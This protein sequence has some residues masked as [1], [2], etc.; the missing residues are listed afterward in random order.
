MYQKSA[1]QA[2]LLLVFLVAFGCTK[3]T[4]SADTAGGG[5][6][7]ALAS[8]SDLENAS[9]S[10]EVA[11]SRAAIGKA[12]E[13][14][15]LLQQRLSAR[16][17]EAMSG[18]GPAAAIE[19]CSEEAQTIATEVGNDLGVKIGRTSFKLR[20]SS[21]QPPSWA[22]SFVAEKTDKPQHLVLDN[23]DTATLLPI[24]LQPQCTACHGDAEALLP[25]IASS[26]AK[27]YPD[28]LATGFKP[29][30]LR[31]WFWIEVPAN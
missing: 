4:P 16:L 6:D 22:E 25:D 5:S 21:N 30:D 27:L 17:I 14:K 28:D 8:T 23:G 3:S 11:P 7:S 12:M 20:N 2:A 19:V 1:F 15:D 26:L 24:T 13:A 29:G 10:A 9:E 18:G 31:G